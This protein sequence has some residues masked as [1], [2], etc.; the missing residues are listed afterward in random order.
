MIHRPRPEP[1]Q[2]NRPDRTPEPN[3]PE[4]TEP[5]RPATP[6]PNRPE[7]TLDPMTDLT[8]AAA[9]RL[10]GLPAELKVPTGRYVALIH[11]A[12]D[13]GVEKAPEV[14]DAM[15][16]ACRY[17][18]IVEHLGK[19]TAAVEGIRHPDAVE[20]IT[21]QL[22]VLLERKALGQALAELSS[23]VDELTI[24]EPT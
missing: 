22:A 20:E 2:P 9:A 19:L 14:A 10:D 3:R 18:A 7:R 21:D 12:I 4:H 6:H 24:G 15:L 23:I 11:A 13:L 1:L 5:H 8:N 16:A 17:D